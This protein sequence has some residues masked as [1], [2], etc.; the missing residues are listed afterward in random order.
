MRSRR[1]HLRSVVADA[2]ASIVCIQETKLSAIS[3][4]LV[5]ETL[6]ARFAS[7]AYLPSVGASGGI[8]VACRGPEVCCTV[9]NS[10]R[11]SVTVAIV[12]ANS[13]QWVLTT[14]YGPQPDIDKVE[15]L[16]ELRSI[17]NTLTGPWIVVGDFN[18]LL[19]ASDKNNV[20]INRRNLGRFRRFVDDLQLKDIFLHGRRYTWSN[21]RN[22]PTMERLDRVLVTVDWE[23]NYPFFY[24]QA[25]S[26][27]FSDH[28]PLLL[29]TN[30]SFHTKRRFHFE[31][32]WIK[33]PGYLDAV[34]AG[35]VCN[36]DF[37]DPLCRI[38]AKL[39]NMAKH[40]QSWSQ[41]TVGQIKSQLLIARTIVSWLDKAQ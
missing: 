18:L 10:G 27:D 15:F 16:N 24:L 12:E 11:Y 31:N 4:F 6:G 33:I 5:S 26:S 1:D 17:H 8:L 38:D 23:L 21:E 34:Q 32:W 9:M 41:R 25:L 30:A 28:C 2:N 35:W 29:S 19:H 7:F 13:E 20:N 3:P 40:L 36:E 14:V 37:A 22:T 39:K